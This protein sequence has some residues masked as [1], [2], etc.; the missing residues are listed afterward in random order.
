MKAP[1]HSNNQIE[2]LANEFLEKF[3]PSLSLPIPIEDIIELKLNIRVVVL[4]GLERQFGVNALIDRKFTSIAI[5]QHLYQYQPER[6]RFTFAEE[7]GHLVLHKDWYVENGPG[8]FEHFLEWRNKL[9]PELARYIDWQ[10]RAFAERILI[11]KASLLE[12]WKRFTQ[13]NSLPS[14]CRV[15]EM[16]QKL[17]ALAKIFEV[18]PDCLLVKLNRCNLVIISEELKSKI[19][20]KR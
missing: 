8:G 4:D 11:P 9:S 12:E 14:K 1:Q 20:R 16:Y 10:A 18:S 13:T 5:D 6:A 2:S 3:H 17:P 7:L 15:E 19:Y